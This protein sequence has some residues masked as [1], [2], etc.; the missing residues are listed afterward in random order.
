MDLKKL[1]SKKLQLFKSIETM[2]LINWVLLNSRGDLRYLLKNSIS[3]DL[4]KVKK[5]LEAKLILRFEEVQFAIYD[6]IGVDLRVGNS[7]G[8]YLQN[9]LQ[10]KANEINNKIRNIQGLEPVKIKK[11]KNSKLFY[12]YLGNLDKYYTDFQVYEYSFIDNFETEYC[13]YYERQGKK[14]T[15][16]YSEN[17]VSKFVQQ[18]VIKINSISDFAKRI[19]KGYYKAKKSDNW[20]IERRD[21]FDKKNLRYSPKKDA[22]IGE[23]IANVENSLGYGID[24]KNTTVSEYYNKI[25]V[26]I[27]KAK[28]DEKQNKKPQQQQN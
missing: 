23:E 19:E 9:Y 3:E 26:V 6:I 13:K 11:Y 28:R 22:D 16:M 21:T 14:E 7:W 17:F 2:P 25:R 24:T 12:E 18:K 1:L 8:R 27:E 20:M 10:H 4:P 15:C 5:S